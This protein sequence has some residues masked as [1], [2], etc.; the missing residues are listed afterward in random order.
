[1]LGRPSFPR[2]IMQQSVL[3]KT[4]LVFVAVLTLIVAYPAQAQQYRGGGNARIGTIG[5]IATSK[6]NPD[7]TSPYFLVI[8]DTRPVSRRRGLPHL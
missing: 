6:L 8:P 7:L 2:Y 1:M 3:T 4:S 5:D